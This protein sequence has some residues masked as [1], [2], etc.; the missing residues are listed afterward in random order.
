MGE[1]L[2]DHCGIFDSGDHLDSAAALLAGFDID[3]EQD[4]SSKADFD[5]FVSWEVQNRL[6]PANGIEHRN[7]SFEYKPAGHFNLATVSSWPK[8]PVHSRRNILKALKFQRSAMGS[9]TAGGI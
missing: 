3:P 6:R 2:F 4:S 7:V 1:G 5:P 9:F 8:A